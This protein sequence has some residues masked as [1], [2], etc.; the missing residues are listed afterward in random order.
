MHLTRPVPQAH[1]RSA[2]SV[3]HVFTRRDVLATNPALM[4]AT[5]LEAPHYSR[6]SHTSSAQGPAQQNNVQCSDT[7]AC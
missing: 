3:H 2:L 7:S 6:K 1:A 4:G 5:V